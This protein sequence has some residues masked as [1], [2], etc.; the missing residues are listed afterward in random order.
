MLSAIIPVSISTFGPVR[1]RRGFM[2]GSKL[3]LPFVAVAMLMCLAF[4]P[5]CSWISG[6]SEEIA[7]DTEQAFPAEEP[8]AMNTP[9]EPMAAEPAPVPNVQ[10][11]RIY[12]A[13][14]EDLF[15]ALQASEQQD[16]FTEIIDLFPEL[17]G[18]DTMWAAFVPAD[19]PGYQVFYYAFY[20][21]TQTFHE[22]V[23]GYVVKN[24]ETGELQG[25]FDG[26]A[27][28]TFDQNTMSPTIDFNAYD[29]LATQR[30]DI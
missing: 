12:Y 24:T 10:Q 19:H 15:N 30:Q 21:P 5:G 23:Y 22:L 3:F 1:I 7:P 13:T 29:S 8:P 9:A 20:T 14:T 2:R 16:A 18:E 27:D 25:Y 4:L 11:E 17:A 6:P 28:E 26:N